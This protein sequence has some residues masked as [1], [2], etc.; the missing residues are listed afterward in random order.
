LAH[1]FQMYNQIRKQGHSRRHHQVHEKDF[2]QSIMDIVWAQAE[3]LVQFLNILLDSLLSLLVRSPV[4][5]GH[6]GND[7]HF[8][9]SLLFS[10]LADLV[11]VNQTCFE[12]LTKIVQRIQRD[13]LADYNDIHGRNRLL[14][15]YIHYECTL[16]TPTETGLT[17]AQEKRRRQIEGSL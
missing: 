17:N 5:N 2:K 8:T 12:S 10:I 15:T 11:N 6:I 16:H 14:L 1:F 13:L 4:L 7:R 9:I 3:K